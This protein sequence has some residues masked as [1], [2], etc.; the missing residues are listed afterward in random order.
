MKVIGHSQYQ[1]VS[2]YKSIPI[3]AVK[4]HHWACSHDY[5]LDQ[6][7]PRMV[8]ALAWKRVAGSRDKHAVG[9]DIGLG[10]GYSGH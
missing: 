6:Q 1:L 3:S 10:V 8:V 4:G 2:L 9:Q 5:S 7:S